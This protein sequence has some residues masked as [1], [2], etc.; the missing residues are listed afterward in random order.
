MRVAIIGLFLLIVACD[1]AN[2][3]KARDYAGVFDG[4]ALRA[5]IVEKVKLADRL[6][7]APS[8]S[9]FIAPAGDEI[10]V[11]Y[12]G[13]F[14]FKRKP[15]FYAA[16]TYIMRFATFSGLK[17]PRNLNGIDGLILFGV[18]GTSENVEYSELRNLFFDGELSSGE[19][20]QRFEASDKRCR[21]ERVVRDHRII[22]TL[23]T[24]S[25]RTNPE[26]ASYEKRRHL[27]VTH[28]QP[29]YEAIKCVNLAH[30]FH[31]GVSNISEIYSE[32]VIYFAAGD[33]P[34]FPPGLSW[35]IHSLVKGV[36]QAGLPR[37]EYL[38]GLAQSQALGEPH[39]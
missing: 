10:R 14:K 16:N 37:L 6:V 33:N 18:D 19:T 12:E 9:R 24:V 4:L 31:L 28:V 32:D 34:V 8:Q 29:E 30:L 21:L 23:A 36:E 15:E 17:Y 7:F 20:V 2:D 5:E 38:H 3:K 13:T 25:Y 35:L 26:S 39:L 27:G 1:E 22:R 11:R